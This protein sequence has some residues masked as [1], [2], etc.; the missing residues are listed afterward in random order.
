MVYCVNCGVKLAETEASCP[1]CR[2]VVCHPDFPPS[3]QSPLYPKGKRPKGV[4]GYKAVSGVILILFLIPLVVGF[5]SDLQS[6]GRLEWFGYMAGAVL[7]SYVVLALPLWFKKSNPVVFVPCDF[8]A[9]M[10]YLWYVNTAVAGHWFWSFALPITGGLCVIVTAIVAL[11]RY[12]RGGRLYIF[13]GAFVL[14]GGWMLML[15][16]L[17]TVTFAI[18]FIGWSLYPLIVLVMLGCLLIYVGI[19]RVA[20]E[21]LERKLFF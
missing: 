21:T 19:D 8:A 2:T 14:L 20:R 13:G 15:E 9:L 7:L 12:V 3:P 11:T 10:L 4:S 1:L 6:N 16:H 18:P 17:L 5:F